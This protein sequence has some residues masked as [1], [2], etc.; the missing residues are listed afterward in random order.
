MDLSKYSESFKSLGIFL[1][2]LG[3]L[4]L[5]IIGFLFYLKIEQSSAYYQEPF[6]AFCSRNYIEVKA[7][8]DIQNVSIIA[9]NFIACYWEVI[10]KSSSRVC[11]I[12]EYLDKNITTF[13]VKSKDNE[14][15]V[16]CYEYK[17][18]PIKD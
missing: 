5:G 8:K 3:I 4:L 14:K 17:I 15:V 18:I 9:D 12:K 10:E 7:Y 1:I 2:G 16:T 11:N 6:S 13:L